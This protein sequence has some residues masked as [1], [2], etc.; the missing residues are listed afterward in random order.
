MKRAIQGAIFV[1]AL[2]LFSVLLLAEPAPQVVYAGITSTATEVPTDVPTNTS[3]PVSTNTPTPPSTNTP[4]PVTN[5][6]TP[7]PAQPT[8]TPGGGGGSTATPTTPSVIG[9]PDSSSPSPT[10]EGTVAAVIPESIPALGVGPGWYE[11]FIGSAVVLLAVL[12]LGFGWRALWKFLQD[13][14]NA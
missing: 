4:T 6:N 5:T 12:L 3:T 14:P 2:I 10:P 13:E 1:S 11:L 7:T 8:S 9:T